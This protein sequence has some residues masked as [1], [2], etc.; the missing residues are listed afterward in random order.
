[1]LRLTDSQ[2]TQF[3]DQGYLTGIDLFNA[4]EVA[5]L[6]NGLD[7][8][9]ALL[10]PGEST[11]EIREWHEASRWLYDYC[12]D[13]RILDCVED[14]LGDYYLWA[15]NYFIK[16]PLTTETV[17]WHQDG[18]YWPLKPVKSATV[19]IGCTDS[20]EDNGAMQVIPGSHKAGLLKHARLDE[21]Q[22]DSVLHLQ[23]ETEQFSEADAQSLIIEAGQISI[24]DDKIVHGSPANPSNRR[25]V[26]LTARYSPTDVRCDLSVNPNF[27]TY[28]CRGSDAYQHNPVGAV[29][30]E[31]F[32]RLE[33]AHLSVEEAGSNAETH[34]GR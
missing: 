10:R 2:V 31:A 20:D 13:E 22:T 15:S 27:K 17:A 14:L 25:R 30:T 6:N 29:P 32:G 16:E 18:Y 11:K 4:D 8:L 28:M 7:Q 9:C 23:C 24:H 19:W 1:M 12:M 3:R 33:Q 5:D 34:L 26:A 21:S